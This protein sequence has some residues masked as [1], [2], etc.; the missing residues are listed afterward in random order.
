MELASWLAVSLVGLV[1]FGW[2]VWFV[3]V[4]NVHN[5]VQ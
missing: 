2:L 4:S 3:A 5:E 1:W